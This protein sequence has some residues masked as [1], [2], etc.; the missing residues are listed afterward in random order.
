M[1]RGL[2]WKL[3]MCL[4]IGGLYTQS[5]TAHPHSWIDMKADMIL[6]EQGRLTAI[7]QHWAFDTYFSMV[8]LADA[9]NEHGD[10]QTGLKKLADEFI[11]NLT[12]FHYFSELTVDGTEIELPRPSSYRL[13]EKTGAEQPILA[14]E[15]RFDMTRPLVI[16]D[17]NLAWSVFDPTYYIAMN[18]SKISNVSIEGEKAARCQLNL[19][20]PSPSFELIEYAQNLDRSRKDTD[21]LGVNFAE[22]IRIAC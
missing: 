8:T 16:E 11:H 18:Y 13:I 1:K 3:V 19:D 2:T 10:K 7:R 9:L 4:L 21:G 12:E 15:M 6:D 5:V 14:L 20:L 22:K 17:K